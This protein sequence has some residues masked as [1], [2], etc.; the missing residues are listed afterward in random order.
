MPLECVPRLGQRLAGDGTRGT[1]PL[2]ILTNSVAVVTDP[3]SG[4]L[5]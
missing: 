5:S 1:V 4:K 2:P 3:A